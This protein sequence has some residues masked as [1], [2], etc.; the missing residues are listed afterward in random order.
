MKKILIVEDDIALREIYKI[1]LSAEGYV[2]VEAENGED[3][4]GK[5]IK[6]RPDLVILDVMMPR[7]SGF[8][9]LELVRMTP[10]IANLKVIVMTALSA[11]EQ[12]ERAEN[13]GALRYIVKSQV[14]IE[15]M[16]GIVKEVLGE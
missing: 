6:E 13:L 12:R 14:G 15:D 11:E 4:V 7:I 16:V 3:A 2:M 10:E 8:E 9:M 1:R 5:I